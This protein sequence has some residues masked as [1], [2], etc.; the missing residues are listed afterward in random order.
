MNTQECRI[1]TAEA[2]G[3]KIKSHGKDETIVMLP[4]EPDGIDWYKVWQPDKDANQMLMVWDWLRTK[5]KIAVFKQMIDDYWWDDK[6][7]LL[8][9]AK[10]FM[11]YINQ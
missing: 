5:V 4:S 7:I 11:E 9:T 1:K 2:L 3:L 6:D 8:A 10:A